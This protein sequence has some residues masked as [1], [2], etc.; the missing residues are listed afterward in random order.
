MNRAL[1]RV[2]LACLVMFVLLLV[3]VNYVQA[4]EASSLANEPGNG[5]ARSPSSSSTSAARSSPPTTRRSRSPCTV[6]G[7][8][9]YQRYYPTGPV[10]APVTGYD[11]IYSATGIEQAENKQLAGTDPALDRAQPAST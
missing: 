3:N 1:R 4:F 11:S 6:K 8:Y 2:S 5:R 7:I 10:Y 9:K